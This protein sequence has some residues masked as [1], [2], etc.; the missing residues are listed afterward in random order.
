MSVLEQHGLPEAEALAGE[1]RHGLVPLEAGETQA[2][3]GR[4]ASGAGR[5]GSF[6]Q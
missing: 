5:H 4:F 3:A 6:G 2:G 1:H